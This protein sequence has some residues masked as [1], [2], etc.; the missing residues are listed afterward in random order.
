MNRSPRPQHAAEYLLRRACR[1][2]P[3]EQAE[4]RFA[5]WSA[6]LPAIVGDPDLSGL[7]A[8]CRAVAF[9]LGQIR[10]TE[11]LA[12]R[13]PADPL[14]AVRAFPLVGAL[15]LLAVTSD[16]EGMTGSIATAAAA[17]LAVV[18]CITLRPKR[19]RT[20]SSA[21]MQERRGGARFRQAQARR[22][23]FEEEASGG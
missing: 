23:V 11:E 6:E 3:E 15:I 21:R 20:Q 8:A 4:E 1:R 5:E 13:Q 7:R 14:D 2:L 12:A 9:A 10:T 22:R 17:V 19:A 16:S 18:G